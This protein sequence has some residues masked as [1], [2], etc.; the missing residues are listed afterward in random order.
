MTTKRIDELEVGDIIRFSSNKQPKT[1]SSVELIK[2]YRKLTFRDVPGEHIY[3]DDISVTYLG[4]EKPIK[5]L[6]PFEYQD[7]VLQHLTSNTTYFGAYCKELHFIVE[8]SNQDEAIAKFKEY[9]DDFEKPDFSEIKKEYKRL[10]NRFDDVTPNVF[11]STGEIKALFEITKDLIRLVQQEQKEEI[12]TKKVSELKVG[13]K[14]VFPDVQKGGTITKIDFNSYGII[15][16][17]N[18]PGRSIYPT[19]IKVTYLGSN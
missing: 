7:F 4:N 1:V 19:D 13:D 8:T 18:L 9:V 2:Q 14:I 6:A 11:Y 17:D 15:E 10:K 3:Y 16:L 12:N 5:N